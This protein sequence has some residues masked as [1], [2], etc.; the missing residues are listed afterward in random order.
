[1]YVCFVGI[2]S[3][4]AY[5]RFVWEFIRDPERIRLFPNFASF[6]WHDKFFNKKRK[7]VTICCNES[8]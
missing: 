5:R 7:E 2:Y 6:C 1:M 8:F 4:N 3:P